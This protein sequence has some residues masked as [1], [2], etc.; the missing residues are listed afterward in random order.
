MKLYQTA[1]FAFIAL[2][3]TSCSNNSSIKEDTT[4]IVE[5]DIN[6]F[7]SK[8]LKGAIPMPTHV[9]KFYGSTHTLNQQYP[10]QLKSLD[11]EWAEEYE[12]KYLKE[13][14]ESI[15]EPGPIHK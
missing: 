7:N 12:S 2:G 1:F 6:D 9:P 3:L 8:E 10:K 15:N 5:L 14:F 4:L 11:P 13:L